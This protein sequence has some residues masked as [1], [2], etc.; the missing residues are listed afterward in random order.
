MMLTGACFLPLANT[1]STPARQRPP[2]SGPFFSDMTMGV[3]KIIGI[4]LIAAGAL[5]LV[6]FRSK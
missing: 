4:L 1:L 6:T 3:A 2:R 5:V